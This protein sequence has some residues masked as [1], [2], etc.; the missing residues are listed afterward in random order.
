MHNFSFI[1]Y[2]YMNK[3]IHISHGIWKRLKDSHDGRKTEK[4]RESS[5]MIPV[6][7]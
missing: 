3:H 7:S 4:T 1:I 6:R 2:A 5:E